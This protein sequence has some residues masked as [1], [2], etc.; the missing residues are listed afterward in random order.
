MDVVEQYMR[1][2]KKAERLLF[3]LGWDEGGRYEAVRE[4][5]R[6]YEPLEGALESQRMN[7]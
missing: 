3:C 6:E 7:R 1:G 5:I 2:G 4:L